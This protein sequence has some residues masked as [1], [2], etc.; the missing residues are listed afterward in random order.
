MSEI[1]IGLSRIEN[2]AIREISIT[3]KSSEIEIE[4]L[5]ETIICETVSD[6]VCICILLENQG[7]HKNEYKYS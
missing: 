5:D 7:Y 6:P 3:I 2:L 4:Y 1:K